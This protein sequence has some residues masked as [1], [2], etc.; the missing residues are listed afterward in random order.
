[1]QTGNGDIPLAMVLQKGYCLCKPMTPMPA[2][3]PNI[4]AILAA[5]MVI[6]WLGLFIHSPEA[7]LGRSLVRAS[8]DTLHLLGSQPMGTSPVLIVFLDLPSHQALKLDPSRPWPRGLHAKLLNRLTQAGARAVVFDIVFD[9]PGSDVSEDLAFAEAMRLNGHVT[10]AGELAMSSRLPETTEGG[11]GSTII[12]PTETLLSSARSWGL[13]ELRLDDDFGVRRHFGWHPD[14]ETPGLVTATA[15][16]LQLTSVPGREEN[17]LRWLRHYGPPFTL[18]H[19]SYAQALDAQDAPDAMFRDKIVFIGA[20]SWAGLLRDRRDEFRSPFG[21]WGDKDVFVSGVELHATQMLNLLRQDWLRRLPASTEW[22]WLAALGFLAGAGLLLLRPFPASCA[23]LG[24]SGLVALGAVALFQR[25][26][27]WFPW[28]IPSIAQIPA[29]LG[30]SFLFHFSEWYRTR[31]R[32]EAA[33]RRAEEKIRE[34]AALIDKAHDA[35]LVQDLQDRIVYAN[36]SAERLLGWTLQDLQEWGSSKDLFSLDVSKR[37]EATKAVHEH[38]EWNGELRLLPRSGKTVLVASRWTLIRDESGQPKE[39]LIMSSDITEQKQLEAQL[40]RAQRMETIGALAGGMAH[41]LN[42]ALSPVLLGTQLLRRRPQD[43]ESARLLSLMEASTL[44]GADMVRQVLLF[45]RGR[46]GDMEQLALGGLVK[47][48]EKMIRETF[49][50]TIVV[51]TWLPP[52]T[53]SVKGNPTQIHQILLNLCV[54][55]RDAMPG[56]GR[57]TLAVDNVS[58]SASE[59]T[60]AQLSSPGDYVSLLVSDTGTG[61]P[62]EVRARMFEPFFTTKGE[63][64]GTGLGLATVARLVKNHGGGLRLE[65]QPG[66]GTTFEI[67]LPRVADGAVAASVLPVP[68]APL[69]H[70]EWILVVDDE[71]SVRDLIAESLTAHNY[72]VM[73]AADRHEV[74]GLLKRKDH[75]FKLLVVDWTMRSEE[76]VNALRELRGL[77]RGLEVILTSRQEVEPLMSLKA[78]CDAFL[79]KPLSLQ[80]V[81]ET[82]HR[83]LSVAV[84]DP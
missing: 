7:P 37:E 63:G 24:A 61:I 35:I 16:S 22:V 19:V 17:S 25:P 58:L 64:Q 15:E 5:G 36:P 9:S 70:G 78:P 66:Q 54:N 18:P 4:F 23:A 84:S 48:V 45:T 71:K 62:P 57:L 29:A 65:S 73:T 6:A 76:G 40:I 72:R 10:L 83:I 31:R 67:L 8:Y 41:D 32:L 34:Q 56:G 30:I 38:G 42:N 81:L 2:V 77:H 75:D 50:S 14:S 20:R 13:G 47:E 80:E 1:M 11:R 12:R 52:D 49:P 60:T 51:E 82:V 69:G 33:R 21:S 53:W 3:R 79:H 27:I 59:A 28:L 39:L 74:E 44:R 46:E 68:S 55:A 43:P 26:G